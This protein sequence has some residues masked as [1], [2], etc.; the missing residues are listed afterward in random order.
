[1]MESR[2]GFLEEVIRTCPYCASMTYRITYMSNLKGIFSQGGC[3]RCGRKGVISSQE[4]DV[5]NCDIVEPI[6][7]VLFAVVNQDIS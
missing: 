7:L 2:E 5:L 4:V 1:M 3:T 6:P